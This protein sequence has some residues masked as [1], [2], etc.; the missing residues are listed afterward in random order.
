MKLWRP[1]RVSR[2]EDVLARID[3]AT[4][5]LERATQDLIDAR[6]RLVAV[7]KEA[8]GDGR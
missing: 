3:E 1:K 2:V 4:V 8:N 6:D 5:L 7:T